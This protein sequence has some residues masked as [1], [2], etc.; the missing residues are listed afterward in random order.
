MSKPH[1]LGMFLDQVHALALS[2]LCSRTH[3]LDTAFISLLWWDGSLAT[4]TG[5]ALCRSR[6]LPGWG[7]GVPSADTHF[8]WKLTISLR[9]MVSMSFAQLPP[10]GDL[11][12]LSFQLGW[13]YTWLKHYKKWNDQLCMLAPDDLQRHHM[14]FFDALLHKRLN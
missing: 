4:E 7:S 10:D 8:S 5:R 12:L 14:N 2:Y 9:R 13:F 3:L 11:S 1:C 6:A